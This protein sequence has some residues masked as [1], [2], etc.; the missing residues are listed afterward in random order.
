MAL[1]DTGVRYAEPSDVERFVRN[2]SFDAE[3]D[4]TQ[5]QVQQMLLE[6]SDEVDRMA[7]RA[8]RLR[9]KNGLIRTVEWPH[10]IEAAHQRRRRR[11]SRHGHITPLNK[12]GQVNLER[13]RV[14]SIE[15]ITILLPE[16]SKDITAE[17]GRDGAYWVDNR[18]G[19]VHLAA[20]EFTVGPVRGGGLVD[21]SRVEISFRYGVDEQGGTSTEALSESVPAAIRRATAKLAAADLLDTDQYGSVVASGPENTPDQSSAAQRLRE[22]AQDTIA[23]YRIKK[24]M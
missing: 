8:W 5:Q 3:S 24:V 13:A 20:E 4:P 16:S 22:E 18:K 14:T 10:E 12:W 21:P 15:N 6:V 19:A 11:T 2:K 9:E 23:R 17:Q 7:R 1:L